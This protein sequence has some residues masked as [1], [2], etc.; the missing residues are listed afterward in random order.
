MYT[1]VRNMQIKMAEHR[2]IPNQMGDH[3]DVELTDG[4]SMVYLNDVSLSAGPIRV[5]GLFKITIEPIE[6]P[7]S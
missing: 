6:G 3:Y 7:G 1:Q 5:G 4:I 2:H